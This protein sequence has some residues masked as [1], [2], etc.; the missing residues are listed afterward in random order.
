MP[1]YKLTY[2]V[3]RRDSDIEEVAEECSIDLYPAHAQPMDE[4]RYEVSHAYSAKD[5][6]DAIAQAREIM[7]ISFMDIDIFSVSDLKGN[8]ILTEE[9]D[10]E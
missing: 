7:E 6:E 5:D 1:T 8:T 9:D 2:G 3:S 10:E 4:D